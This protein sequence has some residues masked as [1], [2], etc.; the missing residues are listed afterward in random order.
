MNGCPVRP[1]LYWLPSSTD[2][3]NPPPTP[4][5]GLPSPGMAASGKTS[6]E[7]NMPVNPAALSPSFAPLGAPLKLLPYV[8]EPPMWPL[9]I[10]RLLP[11]STPKL[12]VFSTPEIRVSA[13]SPV[14]VKN[15]AS[16]ISGPSFGL[17]FAVFERVTMRSVVVPEMER[18]NVAVALL[19]WP[20]PLPKA[21]P[22]YVT[23]ALAGVV[24]KTNTANDAATMT[25]KKL[26]Q[27]FLEIEF[28]AIS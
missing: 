21:L 19:V 25:L 7:P 15:T 17:Y 16:K 24:A 4:S 8:H 22:L 13:G 10:D 18:S 1:P 5:G 14:I 3:V 11:F 27:N 28:V 6:P 26:M 20:A 9:G 23:A 12:L 2:V